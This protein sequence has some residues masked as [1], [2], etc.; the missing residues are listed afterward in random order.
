MS[1]KHLA[2]VLATLAHNGAMARVQL[3]F[4]ISTV[5][6]WAA[7]LALVVIAFERGGAAE[8]GLIGF[9]VG[10]PAIVVAPT[11]AI[12]GDRWPRSRV[13]VLTY[14]AQAV[15]LVSAGVAFA[16]GAGLLGYALGITFS[17][18]VALV[19][20]LLG[21]LLPEIARTPEELTAANVTSGISEGAGAMLGAFGAGVLFGVAGAPA[22]LALGAAGMVLAAALVLPLAIRARVIPLDAIRAADAS[23]G[24][25]AR[26]IAHELAAGAATILADRRLVVLNVLMAVTIGSLGALSVLIVVV[27]IDVL[28]FDANAAGYLTAVGGLGALLGSITASSLVG[29]ERLA[30]PLLAS[31]VGFAIAIAAVGLGDAPLPVIVAILATGIG[32]SVAWVAATT[33]T[34]RLAGDDVMTRVF[35]AS[36]SVQ[37]GSEAIGGLLVPVLVVAVGPSGALLALGGALAVV[38]A[39][40]APTLL[41]SDRVDPAFLR[42]LAVVRAVPMCGPLS[43]P[44]LERLAAGA[45]HV[46]V[47][48]ETEIIRQGEPGHRFYVITS[49][50]VRVV[51]SGHDMGELGPGDSFGEIALLRDV[52]RTATVVATEP[53]ELVAIH[54]KPF[55]EALTGQ[56]RSRV[57][58]TDLVRE[59][60]AADRAAA[61]DG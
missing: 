61:G 17:G 45:E 22:V 3:G 46:V 26:A 44:V 37:T 51:A 29:R 30:V 8:A 35:G 18:L 12:L 55:L 23:L 7:W 5:V 36:E 42:D 54:R 2:G 53:T 50:R 27:A 59:R 34:Q 25:T 32:W 56:P 16:A 38:A 19:R 14:V 48:Q 28:G 57:I 1:G 9:A 52:P 20:P 13:M 6:E 4:L 41:R 43:G 39:L 10:V 31:V 15:A 11:A 40:S 60:L 33:L 58:A 24:E 21:S 47:P 49:G